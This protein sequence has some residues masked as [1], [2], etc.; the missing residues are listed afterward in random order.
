M[1]AAQEEGGRQQQV[2]QRAGVPGGQVSG[3]GSLLLRVQGSSIRLP[4][5]LPLGR[6]PGVGLRVQPGAQVQLARSP[7]VA[8]TQVVVGPTPPVL[9]AHD[10]VL[11]LEGFPP[12]FRTVGLRLKLHQSPGQKAFTNLQCVGS[13]VRFFQSI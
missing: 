2:S 12:G 1:K 7:G 5:R 11:R 6:Q 9:P 8:E 3:A 4:L 13:R 10:V